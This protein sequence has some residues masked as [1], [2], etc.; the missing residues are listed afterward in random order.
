MGSVG[1]GSYIGVYQT[2]NKSYFTRN[3]VLNSG[4][5]DIYF[6]GLNDTLY[7]NIADTFNLVKED[8][9]AIYTAACTCTGTLIRSNF[10]AN[11]IGTFGSYGSAPIYI[12]NSSSGIAIDS[13]AVSGGRVD[14]IGLNGGSYIVVKNNNIVASN[15]RS[16][17]NPTSVNI[18]HSD[19]KN[20]IFY[21]TTHSYP[22]YYIG[23]ITTANNDTSDSNYVFR[24][25]EQDSLYA[26]G[27]TPTYYSLANIKTSR[28]LELHSQTMPSNYSNGVL[29]VNKTLADSTLSFTTRKIDAKGTVYFTNI[30]LKPFQ[31]II[32]FDF[33][34]T[35]PKRVGGFLFE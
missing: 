23:T 12:D 22:V 26:D 25:S 16:I 32:L 8:G 4:Y 28:S 9:G 1:N 27:L 13:N 31:S 3:K 6:Y 29:Y 15:G 18:T 7:R 34:Y 10:T 11:G 14:N 2:G 19:I 5:H 35:I 30:A 20:N 17:I 24:S 21:S 33:P